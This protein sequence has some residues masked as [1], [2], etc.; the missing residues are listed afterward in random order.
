[1][2]HDPGEH[3]G[4]RCAGVPV[5]RCAGV[6]PDMLIDAERVHPCQSASRCDSPGGLCLDRVPGGMPGHAELV[7][8]GRDRGVEMLPVL[9][10][11]KEPTSGSNGEKAGKGASRQS[12]VASEV[13]ALNARKLLLEE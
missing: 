8:Q 2:V 12:S 7:G 4:S 13:W 11:E 1:V 10:P 6:G 5:C 3:T 9:H